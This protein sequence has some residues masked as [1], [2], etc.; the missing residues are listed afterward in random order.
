MLG[1]SHADESSLSLRLFALGLRA[2]NRRL[3]VEPCW[4]L[5]LPRR[6]WRGSQLMNK[7][8]NLLGS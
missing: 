5:M 1:S 8:V 7:V 4:M 6:V 2:N 3:L